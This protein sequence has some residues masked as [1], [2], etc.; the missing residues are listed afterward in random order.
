[1][2]VDHAF[3]ERVTE[4]VP[5]WLVE[6]KVAG[7]ALAVVQDGRPGWSQGFG[8]THIEMGEPVTTDTVFEA[9]SLSKQVAAY[10]A[11]QLVDRGLLALDRPLLT[12]MP[13][14][15]IAIVLEGKEP[16][17]PQLLD[18]PLIE[19]VTGR[20]VLTHVTGLPNSPP[21][22]GELIIHFPPGSRYSYSSVAYGLIQTIIELLSGQSCPDYIQ[23]NIF[24]PF[25][26]SHS[27]FV[28]KG[29][30]DWPLAL[31]HEADGKPVTKELWPEMRAGG[32]LHC[33]AAD[34]ARFLANVLQPEAESPFHL[35]ASLR[36]EM[37]RP[38][39]Q[40]NDSAPWQADWPRADYVLN[41]DV[42]WGLGWGTQ[43]TGEGLAIWQ[44]GDNGVYKNFVLGFSD[45]GNGLVIMTNS[46]NGVHLYQRILREL[47][48]G[49][50]PSLDWLN[51]L[52]TVRV[53]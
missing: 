21:E 32:G 22:E 12:Y 28:W 47:V 13:D 16:G 15:R 8:T 4:F 18:M 2:V 42:G 3:Q 23:D 51:S 34:Y 40:V 41:Q 35:S 11:L 50:Y 53:V 48:G 6:M 27:A 19:Q 49:D 38:H 17:N 14:G 26:M 29:E 10:A 25:G 20:H 30:K 31:G 5:Q 43:L 39:V 33:S 45:T 37:I 46:R 7:A 1:M 52:K 24:D 9:A 36:A 44:W